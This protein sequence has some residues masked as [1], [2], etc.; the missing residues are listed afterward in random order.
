MTRHNSLEFFRFL[1][2]LPKFLQSFQIFYNTST[3]V[4]LCFPCKLWTR[5]HF[6]LWFLYFHKV[7][8]KL[9]WLQHWNVFLNY[10]SVSAWPF[11]CSFFFF[12]QYNFRMSEIFFL[13][14]ENFLNN[15]SFVKLLCTRHS[16]LLEHLQCL[17]FV[18]NFVNSLVNY[19]FFKE[20]YLLTGLSF[21][22]W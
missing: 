8:L 13:F 10:S 19:V 15:W 11:W 16:I 1:H 2:S 7:D 4:F 12:S 20:F 9:P 3:T 6:L 5:P 18:S 22:N 14:S 21:N 17:L